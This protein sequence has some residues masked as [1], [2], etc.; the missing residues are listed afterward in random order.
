MGYN[1]HCVTFSVQGCCASSKKGRSKTSS[2]CSSGAWRPVYSLSFLQI[3]KRK[4]F[5]RLETEFFFLYQFLKIRCI[6][7]PRK[8]RTPSLPKTCEENVSCHVKCI[9]SWIDLGARSFTHGHHMLVVQLHY[10]KA[11]GSNQSSP[12]EVGRDC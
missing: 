12:G 1:M 11:K 2:P 9:Y 7:C 4:N 6:S 5:W 8:V 10:P 3:R